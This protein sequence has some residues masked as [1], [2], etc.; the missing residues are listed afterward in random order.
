MASPSTLP[1]TPGTGT[2]TSDQLHFTQKE[3]RNAF[4]QFANISQGEGKSTKKSI[5]ISKNFL[6]YS[7]YAVEC[8]LKAIILEN[9]RVKTTKKLPKK[10]R[11]HDINALLGAV[12]SV[13]RSPRLHRMHRLPQMSRIRSGGGEREIIPPGRLHE[14]YRYGGQLDP[15]SQDIL[16]R[17]L[18]IL[19]E[20]IGHKLKIGVQLEGGQQR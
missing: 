16:I 9:I 2:P 7:I 10:Y 20:K 4:R 11:N 12:N 14:L 19:F 8:G 13:K 6:L 3:L 18:S 15:E 1:P 5:Q 17:N